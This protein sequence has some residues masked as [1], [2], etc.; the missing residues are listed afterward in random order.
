MRFLPFLCVPCMPS[1]WNGEIRLLRRA[2]MGAILDIRWRST[3]SRPFRII[4]QIGEK[5][6]MRGWWDGIVCC[7]TCGII[8]IGD[9][10]RETVIE[11]G[12]KIYSAVSFILN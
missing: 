12:M 5:T 2:E 11:V 3:W 1:T 4:R 8:F 6:G 10:S 9:L 7:C